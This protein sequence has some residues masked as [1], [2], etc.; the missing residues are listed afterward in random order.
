MDR[1]QHKSQAAGMPTLRFYGYGG[2]SGGEPAPPGRIRWAGLNEG[3]EGGFLRQEGTAPFKGQL[4]DFGEES[5]HAKP[6]RKE[7]LEHTLD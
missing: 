6:S 4:P 7:R 5:N 2:R 3:Q 1:E